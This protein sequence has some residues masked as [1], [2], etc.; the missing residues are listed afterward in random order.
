MIRLRLSL[1]CLAA[2]YG[3]NISTSSKILGAKSLPTACLSA[4]PVLDA[5]CV[6]VTT[7]LHV[8]CLIA[9]ELKGVGHPLEDPPRNP[10]AK[11]TLRS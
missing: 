8:T 4:G 6:A 2:E 1:S 5:F 11:E 3:L 9:S 7:K 10:P